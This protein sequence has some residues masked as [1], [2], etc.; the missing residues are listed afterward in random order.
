[1]ERRDFLKTCALGTA[2]TLIT[3]TAAL[4]QTGKARLYERTRL[5][6][7]TGN[8][9][10]LAG[11]APSTNYVFDYPFASTPCFLLKLEKPLSA[12]ELKTE[13]GGVYRWDGGV[14]PMKNVVAYSA[15]CAHKLAYPSKQVNFISYRK[16]GGSKHKGGNIIAC[17]ADGSV[18]DATAGAKVLDGPA[19]QPLATILLE[20]DAKTDQL[21]A[22]GTLGGE[23]FNEFFE[24][25]AYRLNLE[26]GAG[27]K[28]P[29]NGTTTV[30]ELRLYSNQTA[31]C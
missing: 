13:S 22:V 25:Y 14:G 20:H 18:Y 17:C 16:D 29:V 4:A 30:K 26:K 3:D 7:A 31:Q 28:A 1:M 11:I 21:F 8:P 23:K 5:I 15:I 2:A 10:T 24:K 27:A 6:D 12:V 9:L 19:P